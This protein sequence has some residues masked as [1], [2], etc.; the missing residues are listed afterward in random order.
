MSALITPVLRLSGLCALLGYVAERGWIM[1]WRRWADERQQ[2]R[3]HNDQSD[4]SHSR[5]VSSDR[6]MGRVRDPAEVS[7]GSVFRSASIFALVLISA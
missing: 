6:Q 5:S 4:D 3:A 1:R 2:F 7:G